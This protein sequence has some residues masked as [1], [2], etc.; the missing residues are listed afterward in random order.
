[1]I[2]YKPL[3]IV[4]QNLI[5]KSTKS[6]CHTINKISNDKKILNVT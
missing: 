5:I 2:V 3:W 4:I 6:L 1:M